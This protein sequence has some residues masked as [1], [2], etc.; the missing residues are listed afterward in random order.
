MSRLVGI[1]TWVIVCG[2]LCGAAICATRADYALVGCLV[3]G[4]TALIVAKRLGA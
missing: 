1:A 3:A 2:S 4:A